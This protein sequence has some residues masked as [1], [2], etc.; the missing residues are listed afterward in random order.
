MLRHNLLLIYRNFKRFKS[1]FFINLI[2]LST[3]LACVLFI[4]LWVNDELNVDR[5]HE[6]NSRLFRVMMNDP[7]TE[8]IETSPSTPGILA[9]ALAEEMPEVEYAV[10][11]VGGDIDFTLSTDDRHVLA[12]G[13]FAE[14]E[15]FHIFSF[16]LIEG[17]KNKVLSDKKGVVLSEATAIALFNTTENIIGKAIEW[18]FAYGKEDAYVSG[19]FKNIPSHSTTQFDFALSFDFFKDIV[20]EKSMHWGNYGCGTTVVLKEGTD[21]QEFNTKIKDFVKRKS[22]NSTVTLF[23]RPYS[24]FYLYGNYEN[25][26]QAGGRIE[27]VKLFS[28][29]GIF[30]LLI[31]CINFMNLTTAKASRKIKEVGIKKAIGAS[32][33]TLIFQYLGESLLM[34]FL[35]ILLAILIVDLL[36]PQFNVI[37]DKQLALDFNTN[38][39]VSLISIVLFTGLLAGSYPALYLSGFS[40]AVVLKGRFSSLSVSIVELIARKGLIVFQFTLSIIFIVAVLVIYKQIAFVQTQYLGYDK[41]HVIYFK[42]ESKAA[43]SV[44]TF[45]SEVKRIPGVVNASSISNSIVG[46]QGSST[47]HFHWEGKD[48]D[49][50]IPFQLIT[51]NH[52]LIETLGIRMTEGRAFS[53]EFASDTSG[54]IFNKA[55]IEVMGLKDPVGK[56]FNLWGKDYT[57][58]GVTEDFHFESL[59]EKVKPLFLRLIP[60]DAERIMV[61]LSAGKERETIERLQEFYKNFNPG[62]SFDYKFLD[63]D[64]QAQYN[65]EKRVATLSKYFAGL[66]ILISCLGLFGL[67]AFTAER[68]LKE[69]G[70]RKVLG[71]SVSGI[72][73]L[74]SSD[75]TKIVFISI[76]IALPASYVITKQ[77]LGSFAFKIEL[78]WWY[79]IGSGVTALLIAWLTVGM[80]AIKAARVNPVNCLKD[81]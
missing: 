42:P 10:A 9:E 49:A 36:L 2:G 13:L 24:E 48:P 45:L 51:V 15:L 32:R 37:T 35:S 11:S 41:D 7:R 20:G 27:Y 39:I 76:L 44:E 50:V 72:V 58:I 30:I 17:D 52:D 18:Q 6:K 1:T 79:F 60:Q 21:L 69:I 33:K 77:W 26:V 55:G 5:F 43:E 38:L 71:S 53:R 34:T 64:Y 46:P 63:Q 75:F 23:L 25:G 65:A 61:K 12:T 3:G 8:S 47:G 16:D 59:H 62:F 40:P 19:V 54:I 80:Q 67:A 31:A 68:R 28:V 14:K 29:I 4:Y 81:E 22:K 74:L 70:I 56:T 73:Y 66:A 57:I 78:E